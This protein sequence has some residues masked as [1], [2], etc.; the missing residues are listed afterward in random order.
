MRALIDR[1][2]APDAAVLSAPMLGMN[3]PPLP[4]PALHAAARLMAL[5][6]DPM[7]PAWKWSEKPGELPADRCELLSHDPD[8]YSDEGW[9]REHRPELVMGPASWRWVER[10]YASVRAIEAP[11]ALEAVDVPVLIVS[12]SAD[13]LVSHPANV[14]A[15]RRLPRGRLVP[16]GEGS[17]ARDPARN[18]FRTRPGNGGDR[19]FPGRGG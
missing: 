9:W 1:R 6:G 14:R 3:G 16:F 17:P 5:V 8:R 4:L 19:R 7:R 2:I 11:G 18:R 12:T 10:A 15:A 13:R